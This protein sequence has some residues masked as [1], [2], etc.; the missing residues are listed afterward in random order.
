MERGCPLGFRVRKECT[1]RVVMG[2]VK[3]HLKVLTIP[4]VGN[5][6]LQKRMT[7]SSYSGFGF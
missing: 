1:I 3:K 6:N 7:E 4:K 2:Q 5:R